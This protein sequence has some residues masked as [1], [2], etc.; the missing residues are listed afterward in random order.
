[1]R[2]PDW[3][4]YCLALGAV[5]FAILPG[6]DDAMA[7]EALPTPPMREGRLRPLPPPSAFDERILVQVDKPMSGTGTAFSVNALGQWVTARHVVDGCANVALE[8]QPGTLVPVES[9][10]FSDSRARIYR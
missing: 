10:R 9:M 7:P 3:I 1:M 4:I 6:G 5:L 8:V 2:F